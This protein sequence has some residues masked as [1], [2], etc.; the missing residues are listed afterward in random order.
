MT[1]QEAIIILHNIERLVPLEDTEKEA[2][3]IAIRSLEAWYKVEQEMETFKYNE[4]TYDYGGFDR[5]YDGIAKIIDKHL[6]E[7]EICVQQWVPCSERLPEESGNYLVAIMWGFEGR[8]TVDI[9]Y[10]QPNC[11]WAGFEDK[12]IAWMPLPAYLT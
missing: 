4:H 3:K 1:T 8:Y 6:K 9:D 7:T 5:A 2:C 11:I 10:W 12:V